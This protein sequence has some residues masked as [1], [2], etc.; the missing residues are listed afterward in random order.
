MKR[1]IVLPLVLLGLVLLNGCGKEEAKQNPLEFTLEETTVAP[2][3]PTPVERRP[4]P[5]PTPTPDPD[6]AP[7]PVIDPDPTPT[8]TPTPTP[9]PPV[10]PV[11]ETDPEPAPT[12]PNEAMAKEVAGL[13]GEMATILGSVQDEA[14]AQAANT[15]LMQ[16]GEKAKELLARFTELQAGG[17]PALSPE[18]EEQLEAQTMADQMKIGTEM[19][20]LQTESPALLAAIAPGLMQVGMAMQG[21]EEAAGPGDDPISHDAIAEQV[22]GTIDEYIT[23]L[24]T[25]QDEASAQAAN[26][27]LGALAEKVQQLQA[28]YNALEPLSEAEAEELNAAFQEQFKGKAREMSGA[29]IRINQANRAYVETIRE[30]AKQY[31]QAVR[32][33]DFTGTS[34]AAPD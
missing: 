15:Q 8:P 20:R 21:F 13:L 7:A 9:V 32:T 2:P 12:D 16:L 27:A 6:P 3:S 31:T 18:L 14:S 17:E 30:S 26:E 19:Q 4:E 11:T 10:D 34:E 1:S 25:I 5:T 24:N 22:A 29:M 33:F 28:E 23:I